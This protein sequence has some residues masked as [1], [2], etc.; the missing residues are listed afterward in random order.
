MVD[1]EIGVLARYRSD[2]ARVHG[3]LPAQPVCCRKHCLC[4]FTSQNGAS[5]WHFGVFFS[6]RC[7]HTVCIVN[8]IAVREKSSYWIRN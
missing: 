7:L 4:R 5:S 1:G 3:L 6:L 2:V 8:S